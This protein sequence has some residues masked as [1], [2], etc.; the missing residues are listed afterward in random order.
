MRY[1][2]NLQNARCSISIGLASYSVHIANEGISEAI[3]RG[4]ERRVQ[5][6]WINSEDFTNLDHVAALLE[7][8]G[9]L[10]DRTAVL[11]GPY[12]SGALRNMVM[13]DANPKMSEWL[14]SFPTDATAILCAEPGGALAGLSRLFVRPPQRAC[15]GLRSLP[16]A[17]RSQGITVKDIDK[18]RRN[19]RI[20]SPWA[21]APLNLLLSNEGYRIVTPESA[22]GV[23]R[24]LGRRLDVRFIRSVVARDDLVVREVLSELKARSACR[25]RSPTIAIVSEEDTAYGQVFGDIIRDLVGRREY[26]V[27]DFEVD[28]Y[29]YLRGLDGELPPGTP[30]R[31]QQASVNE[32]P[33]P[34][35]AVSDDWTLLSQ[36]REDAAGAARFDYVRRL[37]D[38]IRQQDDI[39]AG[40]GRSLAGVF[41][42]SR[43][44][45]AVGVLGSDVYDKLVIL[46]ALRDRIPTAVFFTTDLD[47]RL[48]DPINYGITRNLIV[49]ATYGF[50][51]G[52]GKKQRLAAVRSSYEAAMYRA[53]LMVLQ[54]E[55]HDRPLEAWDERIWAPCSRIF[56]I[57]RTGA[58]DITTPRG[59]C[60]GAAE[61]DGGVTWIRSRGDMFSRGLEWLFLFTPMVALTLV[62][63]VMKVGLPTSAQY[64]RAAHAGVARLGA[65]TTGALFLLS[66]YGS[67]HEPAPFFEGVSSVPALVLETT[68]VIFAVC[69]SLITQGRIRQGHC[70]IEKDF[71]LGSCADDVGWRFGDVL[72]KSWPRVSTWKASE[73]A[74]GAEGSGL[75]DLWHGYIVRSSWQARVARNAVPVLFC[76]GVVAVFWRVEPF[77]PHLVRGFRS[78]VELGAA[79]MALAV[80][81]A[82]FF[83][84]DALRMSGALIRCLVEEQRRLCR[85]EG[86]EG[87]RW[88]NRRTLG[89]FVWERRQKM[90]LIVE[91][92]EALG[93]IMVLPFVLL[94]L[95]IAAGNSVSEGWMWSWR[96]IAAYAAFTLYVLAHAL[97]FQFEASRA[98]EQVL[99]ELE[100]YRQM[101]I[102]KGTKERRLAIVV[103]EIQK[104]QKGAFV[105][106]TQHPVGQSIGATGVGLLTLGSALF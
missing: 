42:G 34:K 46:Q 53:V 93:P 28:T 63:M 11:F 105:P 91:C 73:Y 89:G 4:S 56:E 101:T 37:A 87:I 16:Q 17:R 71:N 15:S 60:R 1:S 84:I 106:W 59:E 39:H 104:I 72:K 57:G 100:G 3:V 38:L 22:V 12:T 51:I 62:S 70:D 26:G 23:E 35:G 77:G 82:I 6:L 69:F 32:N 30:L 92:T 47:A 58:V 36:A 74:A 52:D 43:Q 10:E 79:L 13:E 55:R 18:Q 95:P 9:H 20:L 48:T 24:A 7:A 44:P 99:E 29:G 85:G 54:A 94:L 5:V 14:N 97:R 76:L 67:K 102:G 45:V 8:V 21:T 80:L 103:E 33:E 25:T 68:T 41:R 81:V 2:A 50:S 40:R 64:R 19:W 88:S 86:S 96:F 75:K 27:C 31:W 65:A 78:T 49:G 98:K 66:W 90:M 61:V 83:C